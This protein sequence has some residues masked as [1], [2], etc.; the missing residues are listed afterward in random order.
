M[1]LRTV[2]FLD[3]TQNIWVIVHVWTRAEFGQSQQAINLYERKVLQPAR[4]GGFQMLPD[5]LVQQ[6]F[7][8]RNLTA[9]LVH[10]TSASQLLIV[11]CWDDEL[12]G[13]D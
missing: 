12:A 8:I 5:L 3:L 1:S 7:D 6:R 13:S 2:F 10:R 9:R 11:R 4:T